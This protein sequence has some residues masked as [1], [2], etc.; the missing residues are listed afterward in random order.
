MKEEYEVFIACDDGRVRKLGKGYTTYACIS[1]LP[2][3]KPENVDI[4]L[5]KIDGLEASSIIAFSIKLLSRNRRSV[6]LLD[7]LTIAGFNI[8]SPATVYKLSDAPTIVVYT[9]EPS[10]K[11]LWNAFRRLPL[12]SLRSKVLKIVDSATKIST[13]KGELWIVYWKLKLE[14]VKDIVTSLQRHSRV[15]E[16]LRVAHRIASEVSLLLT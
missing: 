7:S 11:R 14:E 1:Y 15:P 13:P 16:P 5:L 4:G 6:L 10:Y 9:Y 2:D 3:L 12:S 8:I